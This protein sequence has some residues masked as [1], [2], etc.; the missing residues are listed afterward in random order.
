MKKALIIANAASMIHLFN[1]EN[2]KLL[3]ENGYE[4]HVACNFLE[5]NTTSSEVVR[6]CRKRWEEEGIHCHQISFMRTP[7]TFKQFSVYNSI[8][9]L[10]NE[11]KFD[12]IHCHTPITGVLTR[13]ASRKQRLLGTKVIYTAHGFHFYKGASLINWLVYFS[14][15]WICSFF[16]DVLL[17]I[18]EE[19]FIRAKKYMHAG[20][21][22]YIPGVGVDMYSIEENKVNR[23]EKLKE[24]G[25]TGDDTVL[26][27]VGELNSNKNHEVIIRA[28][29]ETD[30]HYKYI[31]CG[32]G[33]N[34]EYLKALAE[35][36]GISENVIR[37]DFVPMLRSFFKVLIYFVFLRTV[38]ACHC[39]LWRQ[40]HQS[41]R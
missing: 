15:E 25:I 6:E 39:R 29:A 37:Q 7:F 9:K 27:S 36:L 5:G 34:K 31:I 38:K 23:K 40:W 30:K 24:F 3:L 10:V 12:I 32:K 14:A 13:L 16:T 26:L 4:V 2:I 33:E 18:N 28:L 8:K 17:T 20:L 41:F 22:D 1:E 11:T 21:T 35:K 19:D